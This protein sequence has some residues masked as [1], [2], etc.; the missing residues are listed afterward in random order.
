MSSRPSHWSVRL[1]VTVA[2][3]GVVAAALT[4]GSIGV[5]LVAQ[6]S[7]ISGLDS[8]AAS[9]AREVEALAAGSSVPAVVPNA[10]EETSFVQVV[11][12]HDRVIGASRN[13]S[14]EPPLLRAPPANGARTVIT[15]PSSPLGDSS[16]RVLA[17]PVRLSTGPAWIYVASSLAP[18]TAA[19]DTIALLFSV[20]VP[21]L[22]L[23]LAFTIWRAIGGALHP[24]EAIR[25]EAAG[26]EASDLSRRLPVPR[27]DDEVS[28]LARTMNGLLDRVEAAAIR[29]QEF[30]ADASHELRS[31]VA[32]LQAQIEVALGHPEQ[33]SMRPLLVTLHEQ[34]TRMARLADDLLF[35]AGGSAAPDA[36]TALDLDDLVLAE[37]ARLRTIGAPL[38][39]RVT[40]LSAARVTGSGPAL[41]RLLRNLGD[42]AADHAHRVVALALT[43]GPR[44]AR[45]SVTD[46]G[47]GVPER[48][49]ERVFAR[50]VRL[51]HARARSVT[52]G[53][54]GLGLAIAKQIVERHH[55]SIRAEERT[56]G[57]SG[58]R[59]VIELPLHSG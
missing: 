5:V 6:Q 56:D 45:L 44:T 48:D 4:T 24:I 47:P 31:P 15:Q 33:V 16:L 35:L 17:V 23:V 25:R 43:T 12:G 41:A 46:D 8:T 50:F 34:T 42:N 18:V 9:R 13:V 29:Q 1:R 20:G 52:G 40:E 32:A 36:A 30:V 28:R 59:I 49:R 54:T 14:G 22:L 27:S 51:D 37:A 7:L 10:G 3:T 39:V 2:A 19:V 57:S 53:G 21:A 55:G 38:E 26:I 58:A 11:D